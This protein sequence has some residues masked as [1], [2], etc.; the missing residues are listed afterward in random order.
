MCEK[1]SIGIIAY[2]EEAFLPN[3]LDDMNAQKYPHELMEIILIDSGSSDRTKY[4]MNEFKK[5]NTDFY[6]VQV[7]DNTKKVQAAGW[8]VAIK[9]FTGDV[10]AR[11]DA[12]TKV[13]PEYSER[14]M[15]N[16]KDGE[17]VVGGIRPCIIEKDNSL[18]NVLLQTENSLFGSSINSSR[19][20]Q[21]KSYVKTMFHA[22][23]RREV[24]EK[25]GL[26]NEE[27]LRTEDNEFHYRIRKAGYR[28]CYDP[29]IVSYQYARSDFK[30]MI[31][32]KYGNGYW[33]GKTLK[34]CPGCISIYHLVPFAFVM[35]IILTSILALLGIWQLGALMWG[36]YSVFAI[37]NTVI[38][39][40]KNKFYVQSILMPIMF[41]TLHILYGVGTVKGVIDR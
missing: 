16:I 33:I 25:V 23:Y 5:N 3:L 36:L 6:S 10:L 34:K 37:G 18:A 7:L 32:Q 41:L 22:A 2:N 20:G 26:F 1:L 39:G 29:T 12:H 15:E 8:N 4:L 35:A 17:M 9:N 38:S 27:L 40:I 30:R 14:V 19:R 13:T 31:K 11:I 21:E 28:L 24:F